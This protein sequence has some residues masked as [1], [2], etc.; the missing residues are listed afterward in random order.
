MKPSELSKWRKEHGYTQKELA[1]ILGVAG[2]TIYRWEKSM[3]E[4][5]SF[6]HL[7][8]ECIE[9]K[10]DKL[11]SKGNKKGKERGKHGKR[12]L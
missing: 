5:P 4:I 10:G 12:H 9:K 6:L 1:D 8:L 3:R 2:N 7:T 11:K